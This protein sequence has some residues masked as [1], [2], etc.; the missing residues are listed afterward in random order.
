MRTC[1]ALI[2]VP[3]LPAADRESGVRRIQDHVEFLVSVGWHHGHRQGSGP[4]RCPPR[5]SPL[6]RRGIPTFIEPAADTAAIITAGNFDIARLAFGTSA[7]CGCHSFD[8][9]RRGRG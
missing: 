5:G 9:C 8:A 6:R 2:G 1:T 3:F 7:S 4:R